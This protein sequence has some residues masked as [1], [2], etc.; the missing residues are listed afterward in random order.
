VLLVYNKTPGRNK[1]IINYKGR[2]EMA[3]FKISFSM[4]AAASNLPAKEAKLLKGLFV[5]SKLHFTEL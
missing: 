5:C 1:T 2:I 3:K 4:Q